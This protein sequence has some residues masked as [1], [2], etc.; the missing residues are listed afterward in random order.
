M[1]GAT[2]NNHKINTAV[3][4]IGKNERKIMIHEEDSRFSKI[5]K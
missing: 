4:I 3:H 2:S 1:A 5:Q